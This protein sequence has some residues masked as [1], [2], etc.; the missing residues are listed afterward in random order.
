MIDKKEEQEPNWLDGFTKASTPDPSKF[1]YVELPTA[2]EEEPTGSVYL[3]HL[4]Q[5]NTIGSM[6]NKKTTFQLSE[7]EREDYDFTNYANMIPRD[8]IPYAVNFFGARTPDEFK[9]IETQT[10]NEIADKSLIT[11]N[12]W[13]S[14]AYAI[15][16]IEPTNWIPGGV[17]YKGAKLGAALARSVMGGAISAVA[18]TGAQE[19]VFHQNQSTRSMQ[20]SIFNVVGAGLLGGVIGGGLSAYG[21]RKLVKEATGTLDVENIKANQRIQADINEALNPNES[22]SAAKSTIMDGNEIARMPKFIAKTMRFSPMN[23]LFNSTFKTAQWFGASAYEHGYELVKNSDG[24]TSGI[25]LERGIKTEM[26]DLHNKQIEHMNYFYEMHGVTSKYFKATRKKLAELGTDTGLNVNLDQFNRAVYETALTGENHEIPQVNKAATMWRKEFDRLKDQA[27]DLGLLPEGVTVPNAANYIMVMYNKNKII[28]QGGKFARG[29]GTFPQFLFNQFQASNETLKQYL[30]SPIVETHLRGIEDANIEMK[31][32]T[33]TLTSD[34]NPKVALLSKDLKKAQAEKAKA[35]PTSHAEY[36]AKIK[37]LQDQIDAMREKSFKIKAL[38][39]PLE[40]KIAELNKL[41]LD[42]APEA[43][44]D[45]EGNIHKVIEGNGVEEADDLIWN[46]VEQTIDHILG[47]SD[48]KLLNPF[49]QKL[50]GVTKPFKAR[51]LI[52]DQLSASPWHIT[53][54]QQIAEAHNRAMVPAIKLQQFAK[55]HGFNDINDFLAG[56]GDL[57]RKEFDAQS[58]G[59]TG[60]AAM[61]CFRVMQKGKSM[62]SLETGTKSDAKISAVCG[63]ELSPKL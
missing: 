13:K 17:I 12:P 16:P 40:K 27:V 18:S 14:L 41:I 57:L 36:D 37:K 51:K 2:M 25:S 4:R 19:A 23:R 38:R 52:V 22:L 7:E 62:Q 48:G 10:R 34:I 28:E 60:K 43:A 59:L 56:M 3:A 53:D 50:G 44:K 32:H 1:G 8:L 45:W 58:K 21:S 6:L 31:L 39:V 49:L 54:I 20:E 61:S 5:E 11:A 24:V 15:D 47:D 9:T 46:Q 35:H 55:T 29:E 42:G 63:L 33:D 26:R 30:K